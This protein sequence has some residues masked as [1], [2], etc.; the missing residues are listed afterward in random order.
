MMDKI[1]TLIYTGISANDGSSIYMY[2]QYCKK[3]GSG[4]GLLFDYNMNI[5]ARVTFDDV[6]DEKEFEN[7]IKS[8]MITLYNAKQI[9]FNDFVLALNAA[10]MKVSP[11]KC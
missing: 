8:N 5:K 10:S 6:E 9:S 11:I 7:F 1:S 4:I 3:S 2:F